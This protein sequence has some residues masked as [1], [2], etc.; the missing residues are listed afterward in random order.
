MTGRKNSRGGTT[1]VE[2]IVAFSVL[3]L[4]F[5]LFSQA[6]GLTE[7]MMIRADQTMEKSRELAKGYYLSEEGDL[8]S[9]PITLEFELTSDSRLSNRQSFKIKANRRQY[10]SDGGFIIDVVPI[11]SG[12]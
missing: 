11:E 12:P 1:M 6:M 2:V 9:S 7:R 4:I 8:T 10:E 3:L 5:G